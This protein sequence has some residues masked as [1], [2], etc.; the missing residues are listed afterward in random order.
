MLALVYRYM[1]TLDQPLRATKLTA[2]GYGLAL[3]LMI[4]AGQAV[5]GLNYLFLQHHYIFTGYSLPLIACAAV[6]MAFAEE[7][8][9]R[10]L[11]QQQ[12]AKVFHPLVAAFGTAILYVL[13]ALDHGTM[14]SLVPAMLLGVV[15]S[16]TYYKKQ[17]L[18][19]TT[20]INATAKLTYIGLVAT[21]ILR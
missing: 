9:L 17:N 15:L 7:M 8:L 5:G 4:V 20:T 13:L 3:P 10:G 2:R 6:V 19:L 21:F 12:A 14:L 11:I 16:F 18:I 1:F